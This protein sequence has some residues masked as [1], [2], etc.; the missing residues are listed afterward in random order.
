[1]MKNR[2]GDSPGSTPHPRCPRCFTLIELLV[3]ISIIALLI[4][5]LLPALGSARAAARVAQCQ[6]NLRQLILAFGTYE[7]AYRVLPPAY[8]R[9]TPTTETVWDEV[10]SKLS[11]V[12][13]NPN[14]GRIFSSEPTEPSPYHCNSNPTRIGSIIGRANYACTRGTGQI[15]HPTGNNFGMRSDF[16]TFR[17]WNDVVILGDAGTFPPFYAYGPTRPPLCDYQMQGPV[18]RPNVEG[19]QWA[20][21]EGTANLA[22]LDAHVRRITPELLDEKLLRPQWIWAQPGYTP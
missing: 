20:W 6:A 19:L 14:E 12:L 10:L 7:N 16:F 1:M 18:M 9:L 15:N 22:F 2:T 21:H 13:P 17:D 5:L 8:W 3:V 11:G 4:A